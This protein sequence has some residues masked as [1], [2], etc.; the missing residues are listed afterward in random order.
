[1]NSSLFD[2]A[3]DFD[4]PVAVLKHC[5][6]RIRKQLKTMQQLGS[7]AAAEASADERRQ[8]AAAVLRYFDKAAPQ[9]HE[10]EEHD[11]LPM[12]A[13]TA[14]DADAMLLASLMPEVLAEH[15]EMEGLWLRLQPQLAALA[16]GQSATLDRADVAGFS[17]L[18]LRHME[19]EEGHIAT[20]ASRLFSPAQ[21]QQ[22]GN[23]MRTRRGIALPDG[24]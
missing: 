18:Y 14:R 22:L 5:H 15:R 16:A 13:S 6:D 11:L 21:M 8:A 24:A 4:L 10:D 7:P 12:L 19:K 17:E 1:M 23:A 3:P 9:H 20:M 2:T